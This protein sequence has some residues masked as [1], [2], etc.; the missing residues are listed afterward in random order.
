MP[1]LHD[2][3]HAVQ[4]ALMYPIDSERFLNVL[5]MTFEVLR[6]DE[7]DLANAVGV[8]RS[9]VQRWR[10]GTSLPFNHARVPIYNAILRRLEQRR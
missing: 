5:R 8:S 10:S 4:E 6:I 3:R 7:G 2:L 1:Q 9:A